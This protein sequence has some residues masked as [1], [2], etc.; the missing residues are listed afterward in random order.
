MNTLILNNQ[1]MS[2]WPKKKII[3]FTTKS[4]KDSGLTALLTCSC[5]FYTEA[6]ES[7][8][9]SIHFP[10]ELCSWD[11]C[12]ITLNPAV[13]TISQTKVNKFS[14]WVLLANVNLIAECIWLPEV[15]SDM[16][17]NSSSKNYKP[18]GHSELTVW[19]FFRVWVGVT[20]VRLILFS[21]VTQE[22]TLFCTLS[23]LHVS[24]Q[25]TDLLLVRA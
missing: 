12:C 3:F 19:S 25:D 7:S 5:P 22:F 14:S 20:E 6:M 24:E 1:F 4:W 9:S 11:S 10:S 16:T 21:W 15:D 17:T 18:P 23:F 8:N 2:N 13:H